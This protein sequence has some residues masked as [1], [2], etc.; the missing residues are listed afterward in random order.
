MCDKEFETLQRKFSSRIHSV[1]IPS[2]QGTTDGSTISPPPPELVVNSSVNAEA[3]R[4]MVDT[5]TTETAVLPS[6]SSSTDVDNNVNSVALSAEGMEM[7]TDDCVV[8][9]DAALEPDEKWSKE[10]D[11]MIGM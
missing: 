11:I 8:A 5:V 7:E 10:F 6:A 9:A 2:D 1:P 4:Q 3:E